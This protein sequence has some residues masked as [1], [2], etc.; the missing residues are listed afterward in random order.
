M[1]ATIMVVHIMGSFFNVVVVVVCACLILWVL[2]ALIVGMLAVGA[3]QMAR[4]LKLIV[5]G[6]GLAS[7]MRVLVAGATSFEMATIA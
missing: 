6:G 1:A 4:P 2:A 3:M 7:P 5:L